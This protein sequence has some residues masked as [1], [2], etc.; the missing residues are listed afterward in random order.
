MFIARV[1]DSLLQALRNPQMELYKNIGDK[2][3]HCWSSRVKYTSGFVCSTECFLM[4][5]TTFFK[6]IKVVIDHTVLYMIMQPRGVHKF[7]Q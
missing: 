7:M 5:D 6:V 2:V 1:I 4:W 3:K